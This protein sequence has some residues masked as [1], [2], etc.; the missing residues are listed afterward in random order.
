MAQMD[1]DVQPVHS[2]KSPEEQQAKVFSFRGHKKLQSV[3]PVGLSSL[4]ASTYTLF[5]DNAQSFEETGYSMILIF[6]DKF[7]K[8]IGLT[9]QYQ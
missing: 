4:E 1:K 8:M 6:S 9:L 7:L 3:T 5:T 2:I